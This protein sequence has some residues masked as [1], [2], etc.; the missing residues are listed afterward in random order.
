MNDIKQSA[1][2]KKHNLKR[3]FTTPSIIFRGVFTNVYLPFQETN[4]KRAAHH[5]STAWRTA[6]C[7]FEPV[8]LISKGFSVT[9]CNS[10]YLYLLVT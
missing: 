9:Y 4:K 3:L 6:H 7:I 1:T 8:A 5:S 2:L 10:L